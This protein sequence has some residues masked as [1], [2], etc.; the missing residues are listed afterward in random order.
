MINR[1]TACKSNFFISSRPYWYIYN[2]QRVW[3]GVKFGIIRVR[4]VSIYSEI[5]SYIKRITDY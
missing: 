3:N 1:E 4:M 5:R 2:F